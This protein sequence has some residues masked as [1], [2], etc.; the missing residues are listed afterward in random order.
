M[1]ARSHGAVSAAIST[2]PE[3]KVSGDPWR[4]AIVG[5]GFSG[6]ALAIHLL[7]KQPRRHRR[8]TAHRAHRSALG[9]RRRRRL[10]H[11]RL[12]LSAQ[13]GRRADVARRRA[14]RRLPR[15]L[16]VAGHPCR[17]R[18]LSTAPGVRR[19]PAR[20]FRRSARGR[21]AERRMR[22]SSAPA[23]GS[24]GA[25]DDRWLL[26]LDDGTPLPADD[27]VLA[28]GNPPPAMPPELAHLRAQRSIH[29]R[30]VE[31]RRVREQED[32]G[33]VLLR[34]Q[35]PHD[36]RRGAA[37]RGP[38]AA[39]AGT[40]TCCRATAGCRSRRPRRRCPRSSPMWPAR[41]RR[42]AARRGVSCAPFVS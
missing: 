27:V 16:R 12:S 2:T 10:C 8:A 21:A 36:G 39:R 40:S 18:R 29:Q 28:L 20:A 41:S 38:A 24:C 13:R 5:A 15:L 31:H 23:R 19:L 25:I 22:S 33:S 7:Q 26:W 14:A 32:I 1:Q 42:R 34:R 37:A 4:V 30:S 9:D 3:T 17:G 35:R 11:A 6:T